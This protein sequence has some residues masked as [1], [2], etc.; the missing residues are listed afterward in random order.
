MRVLP[1][2]QASYH[3]ATLRTTYFHQPYWDGMERRVV[4]GA[5]A[6]SK[7]PEA[8]LELEQK[9]RKIL[10]ARY[11]VAVNLG[12]S[13][14]TMA[15]RAWDFGRGSEVI[16][17]SFLCGSVAEAILAAGLVPVFVDIGPDFNLTA[18]SVERA[19]GKKTR[20]IVLVHMGGKFARDSAAILSLARHHRLKVVDDA[21]LAFGVKS[22]GVS[23]GASGDVGVVSFGPGKPL[24]GPGGG[25]LVTNDDQVISYCQDLRLELDPRARV[26]RRLISF[27]FRYRT[28]RFSFPVL[29]TWS[30]SKRL[31]DRGRPG[32]P[33]AEVVTREPSQLH[34]IEAA[35][36]LAQ[37]GK[38]DTMTARRR[39]NARTLLES[40]TLRGSG[41][42][43]PD[44]EAHGF[45][46]LIVCWE[47]EG[48]ADIA[49]RFRRRLWARGV[50]T[51]QTYT[52]LHLRGEFAR[53]RRVDLSTTDALWRGAFALPVDPTLHGKP[54]R[55][56]AET[57][58]KAL[59]DIEI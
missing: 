7:F 36:A 39:E 25:A 42:I 33:S 26:V 1:S 29:L 50:Q 30:M 45:A 27:L 5:I 20:A 34:G 24:F 55:R 54:M 23:A 11:C 15:L 46:K 43:I 2:L 12:R 57:V 53:F 31:F 10:D 22:D 59:E 14:I 38:L 8:R 9:L 21:C 3:M 52:P 18:E 41:A 47:G 32:L 48:G 4:T 58:E 28:Q 35:L 17:P 56:L 16:A 37:L 49:A 19:I 44:Q 51:E 13:A 40:T 6:G